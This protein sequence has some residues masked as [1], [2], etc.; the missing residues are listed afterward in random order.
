MLCV[1]P[2]QQ[3]TAQGQEMETRICKSQI[4][5]SQPGPPSRL[6]NQPCL[7][8]GCMQLQGVCVCV[9]MLPSKPARLGSRIRRA[10]LQ[11]LL[12]LGV[13]GYSLSLLS[14][15]VSPLT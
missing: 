12:C 8:K 15:P 5:T 3:L 6:Q 13:K 14:L 1:V 2:C 10:F 4:P 7:G 11:R 9:C